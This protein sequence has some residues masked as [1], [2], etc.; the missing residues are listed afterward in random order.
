VRVYLPARL[1]G[2]DTLRFLTWGLAVDTYTG[3]PLP[4]DGSAIVVLPASASPAAQAAALTALGPDA[5]PLG[6]TATYPGT[7]QP[8][9]LAFGRGEAAARLLA[10]ARK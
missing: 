6:A 9:A 8:I 5:T 7:R 3:A 4:A 10:T 2:E 1:L